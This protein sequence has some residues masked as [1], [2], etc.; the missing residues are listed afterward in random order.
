MSSPYVRALKWPVIAWI[1][2]DVFVYVVSFVPGVLDMMTP[3]VFAALI[4]AVGAWAGY[5][6]VQATGSAVAAVIAGIVVGLVCGAGDLVIFGMLRGMGT[7]AVL[8][9]A[10]LDF[11]LNL[12]GAIVGGWFL[13]SGMMMESR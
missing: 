4:A 8:P 11:T 13:Y 12:G 3:P 2:I 5:R 9:E 1:V 10:V 7:Q 6:T